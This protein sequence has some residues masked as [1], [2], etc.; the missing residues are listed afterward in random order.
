MHC[1]RV[2]VTCGAYPPNASASITLIQWRALSCGWL[3][4]LPVCSGRLGNCRNIIY[5]MEE[6]DGLPADQVPTQ[7]DIEEAARWGPEQ[8]KDT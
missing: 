2:W 6:E 5:G 3:T 8:P 7:Q 4:L 1:W